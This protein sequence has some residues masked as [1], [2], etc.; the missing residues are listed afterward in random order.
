MKKVTQKIAIFIALLALGSG[1]AAQ[2]K[3]PVQDSLRKRSVRFYAKKLKVDS[4]K[5][6][7]VNSIQDNYKASVKQVAGR[8][9]L[10]DAQKRAAIDALIADKNHQLVQLLT[11]E[12]QEAV[13]PPNE[14]ENPA[15]KKP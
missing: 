12:Q 3:H 10:T 14:R 13:I 1:A 7:K 15:P 6:E 9:D 2:E 5:A 11:R 4:A 8:T